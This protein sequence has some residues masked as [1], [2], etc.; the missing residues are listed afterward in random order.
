VTSGERL[1]EDTN[2]SWADSVHRQEVGVGQGGHLGERGDAGASEG[3]GGGAFDGLGQVA[4]L[5]GCGGVPAATRAANCFGA[6]DS[7]ARR[8]QWLNC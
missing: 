2:S 5:T 3:P 7:Q 8:T 4:D 6:R 1:A